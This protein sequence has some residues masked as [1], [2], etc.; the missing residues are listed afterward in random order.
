MNGAE[1]ETDEGTCIRFP[2]PY[3][4]RE[5]TGNQSFA[6]P[7]GSSRKMRA[8]ISLMVPSS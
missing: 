5:K 1:R 6:R 8:S 4:M 3:Y 7:I 2:A